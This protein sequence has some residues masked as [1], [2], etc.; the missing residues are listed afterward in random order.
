MNQS[1]GEEDMGVQW[2]DMTEYDCFSGLDMHHSL[3][4]LKFE[5]CRMSLCIPRSASDR[6]H[7]SVAGVWL[8]SW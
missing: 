2:Q 8:D 7:P 1:S 4:I 3:I 5:P 6:P